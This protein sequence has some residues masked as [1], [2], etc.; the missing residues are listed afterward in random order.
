MIDQTSQFYA[1]LTN[2]GVAKQT[3]ADALGIAW[4]ITQMGVGDANGAD[5]QPAA[6]QTA[7]INE[8]RRAPLNQ[9]KVDPANSAIIIAEQVIPAEVGGWWIREIGLYDADNDLVAIANCA[10]SF[11]P[12]L[13]QGSGRTQVV[14]M[15]LIVSNSAS[16]E[17]KIDPSVVLATRDYVDTKVQE[18]I[19]KLDNKQSVKIATT[20][21]IALSAVQTVD[22]V[23]LVVGDRVLVKNQTVAKDNGI[24]IV[25][26][27]NWPRALDADNSSEVTSALL[28]SVEQGATQADTRWQLITDSPIVLGTTALTFQNVTQG[29][30][31]LNSPALIN[32]TANTP[33]QFDSS[34]RVQTTAFA[35]RMGVE[36]SGFAP[37]TASTALGASSIG[38]VVAGASATPISITLPPTAGV[39][40]AATVEVVNSGSGALTVLPAGLDV[41]ASPVAG[42]VPVVLGMGDNAEFI[43]VSGTWRLRGGSMA[44]KYAAVMA[45]ANWIT[46]PQFDSTKALATTEFTQRALGNFSGG[47][48]ENAS[49][50]TLPTTDVGKFVAL[51]LGASQTVALPLLQS[52][53]EGA[54]I[55]LHN[56]T[57]FDKIITVNGADKL[58][59][60]G[61]LYTIFTLK[62]G[63]TI[64]VTSQSSVWRLHG[65]G[66]MKYSAQFANLLTASGYQKQPSGLIMQWGSANIGT[67]NTGQTVT[68]PMT[69]PGGVLSTMGVLSNGTPGT[70]TGI[71]QSNYNGNSSLTISCSVGGVAIRY[72]AFGY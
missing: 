26:A 12:L 3:N 51:Y 67:A 69:F 19:N 13:T 37:L 41:L 56:P 21:N 31:A 64:N 18:E 35:K 55:T 42:V 45:G 59:P 2:I 33:P 7:L 10:P 63:D 44:L 17:L 72:L 50:V 28:M 5:P 58:S 32:P 8:R 65:V 52:V 38:G 48:A 57:T 53:Q 22:G 15:N 27:G 30:A 39:P 9:L 60:D 71:V 14:R 11:K 66:A 1:I 62:Q 4:K 43:K 20:A 34:T 61:T 23:A 25:A 46:Q 36:Y 68:Y 47:R 24:Y 49:G 29:F 70:N 6:T 40:E 54:T 16:V